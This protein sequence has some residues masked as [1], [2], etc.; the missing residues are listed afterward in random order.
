MAPIGSDNGLAPVRWQAIIWINDS[1]VY[2]RIYELTED[3]CA[4]RLSNENVAS[5][6]QCKTALIPVR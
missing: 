3:F 1:L 6:D 4:P 2:W 5:R